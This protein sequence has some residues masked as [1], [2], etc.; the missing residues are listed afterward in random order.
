[1]KLSTWIGI[2][3]LKTQ[4]AA[5]LLEISH[6][7]VYKYLYDKSIPKFPIMFKIFINTR[8][9]VTANDFYGT[10]PE[11]LEKKLIEK[12]EQNAL[13]NEE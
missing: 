9:S 3:E 11:T 4:E 1:M 7:H 10:T 5:K 2:N 13:K 12:L 6:S 8:G